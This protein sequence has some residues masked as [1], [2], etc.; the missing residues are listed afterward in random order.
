MNFPATDI[1]YSMQDEI[2]RLKAR[3]GE[4]EQQLGECSGGFDTST[5]MIASL[6]AERDRL[7]GALEFYAD[8]ET[9]FGVAFMADRPCGDFV[10]DFEK[11]TGDL[12][13]PDGGAWEKPGKRARAAL[14]GGKP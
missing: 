4:L 14:D 9:Y 10:E 7:R 1:E 3:I 8:P 11:L 12:G 6:E 2:D 5:K 13:H